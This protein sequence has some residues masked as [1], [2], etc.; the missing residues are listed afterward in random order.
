MRKFEVTITRTTRERYS[1]VAHNEQEAEEIATFGDLDPHD[2]YVY[3]ERI[4]TEL[5]PKIEY[6]VE[7]AHWF[8]DEYQPILYSFIDRDKALDCWL[9]D[10][11][12]IHI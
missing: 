1:I 11:S 7:T 6:E 12:L 3:E 10:L 5:S 9:E 8:N 4:D 2:Y